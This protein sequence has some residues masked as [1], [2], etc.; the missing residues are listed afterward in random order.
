M[1]RGSNTSSHSQELATDA[2]DALDD[3]GTCG[4]DE[5]DLTAAISAALSADDDDD[6]DDENDATAAA[7]LNQLNDEMLDFSLDDELQND[8]SIIDEAMDLLSNDEH[9]VDAALMNGS[10]SS[11]SKSNSKILKNNNNNNDDATQSSMASFSS[12]DFTI[13]NSSTHNNMDHVESKGKGNSSGA[14]DDDD[15]EGG[16]GEPATVPLQQFENALAL[17]QDLEKQ[18]DNLEAVKHQLQFENEELRQQNETQTKLIGSYEKKLSEFPKLMEA[19]IEEQTA[20]AHHVAKGAA[21]QSFWNEYMSRQEELSAE[22]KKQRRA[23]ATTTSLKQ[24]DFLKNVVERQEKEKSKSLPG[25]GGG[26]LQGWR[27]SKWTTSSSSSSKG[28]G[29]VA[30]ASGDEAVV[31]SKGS[32]SPAMMKRKSSIVLLQQQNNRDSSHLGIVAKDNDDK[33]PSTNDKILN[34]LT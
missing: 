10:S 12:V 8:K 26:M 1:M 13:D 27:L 33:L 6:L 7:A 5:E 19:T 4:G 25:T 11:F 14:D 23:T 24:A 29:G 21:K 31:A 18:V 3:G 32:S 17:I 9:E 22:E 16:G 34:L 28:N 20:V 15:D 2:L 30:D